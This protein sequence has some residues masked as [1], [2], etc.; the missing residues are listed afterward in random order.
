MFRFDYVKGIINDVSIQN[1]GNDG[2]DFMGSVSEIKNTNINNFSDKGI[3]IGEK[4]DLKINNTIL[5]NGNI[6]IAV[7]DDSLAE[8]NASKIVNNNVGIDIYKKNWRFSGPGFISINGSEI[9]KNGIDVR[10]AKLNLFKENSSIIQDI[11]V[12]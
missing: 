6:G 7:K 11:L 8:L 9:T 12:D 3:S 5:K 2:L 1:A 10:T 4:S